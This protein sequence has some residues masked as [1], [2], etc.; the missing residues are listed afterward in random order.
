M[1]KKTQ[2]NKQKK[3]TKTKDIWVEIQQFNDC[4][5]PKNGTIYPVGY[6]MISKYKTVV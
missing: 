1:W 2:K 5:V 3:E 6:N 4:F